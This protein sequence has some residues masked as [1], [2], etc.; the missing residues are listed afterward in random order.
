MCKTGIDLGPE[1]EQIRSECAATTQTVNGCVHHR[2]KARNAGREDNEAAR[3]APD[4]EQRR[5][6]RRRG[7]CGG[8]HLADLVH[9]G[10]RAAVDPAAAAAAVQHAQRHGAKAKHERGLPRPGRK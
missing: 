2:L 6:R 1:R 8:D 4:V 5:G 10:K 7:H 3:P 9:A